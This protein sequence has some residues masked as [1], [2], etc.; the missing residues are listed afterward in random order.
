METIPLVRPPPRRLPPL[1]TSLVEWKLGVRR[2]MQKFMERLGNFLSG[3]ETFGRG[4]RPQ[5]G[6][7]LETSL[8]EWKPIYVLPEEEDPL[9]PWKLP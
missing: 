7:P 5:A 9:V 3:M 1:E 4:E 2:T 6:R 8:V